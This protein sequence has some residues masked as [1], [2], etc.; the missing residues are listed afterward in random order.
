[1]S[2]TS[3]VLV[4]GATGSIGGVL[5]RELRD[6]SG[7]Y[8][9]RIRAAVRGKT[10]AD[11]LR[12]AGVEVASLNLD[13]VE[14]FS[15]SENHALREAMDGIDQLFL[16]TGYSVEM[17]VQSKAII[18]TAKIAGVKH[19]VHVGAMSTD[20]TT[21]VHLGWHQLVERYIESSGIGF[22]HLRPTTFM[23]NVLRF[24]LQDDGY[25]QQSIGSTT[26]SWIDTD[27]VARA[28]A[29]VLRAPYDHKGR[30]YSLASEAK[31][32]DE[33]T[34]IL[35]TVVGAP[36]R[37]QFLHPDDWLAAALQG[38]M[39]PAYA[40]CVRNVFVRTGEGSLAGAADVTADFEELTGRRAMTWQDHAQ[41][42]RKDYLKRIG[43]E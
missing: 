28:A 38:G 31:D 25:I 37:N 21:I 26:V 32:F 15:L 10:A 11:N 43:R 29:A 2:D 41:L 8:R 30:T 5:V 7:L 39:E 20:D 34:E 4:F 3:S 42:H 24:G 6:E 23:Q 18:D 19:I 33:V 14:R 36:F 9:F 27:D 40:R 17:L 12:Q 22:T 16:L 35:S 13:G 1:M